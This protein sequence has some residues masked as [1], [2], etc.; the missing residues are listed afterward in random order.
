MVA[1]AASGAP[2]LAVRLRVEGAPATPASCALTDVCTIGAGSDADVI[3][4]DPAVSRRHFEVKLTRDGVRVR[5]LGSRNG[6]YYLGQRIEAA[7][8]DLGSV[9]TI[10]AARVVFEVDS[11]KLDGDAAPESSYDELLGTSPG[12]RR[13]FAILS[14][15]EGS[16]ASVLVEG[17]TGTGKEVVARAIHRRSRLASKSLV[18][19]NCGALDREMVKADL[20]GHRKGAFTG[21]VETRDGAFEMADG[22][23]LFLD[24]V[25]EVPLEVQPVLLRALETG[26]VVRVGED[27]ARRVTVRVIAAT[28]RDLEALV[29]QGAFREDLFYRL[30]VVRLSLPPL[31][32]RPE[33]VAVLARRFGREAG[34]RELPVDL[35]HALSAHSWPGNARELRNA[36]HAYAAIGTLPPSSAADPRALDVALGARVSFETTYAEQ[37]EELLQAFTSAYLTRLLEHTDGNQSEAA[38]ISGLERSY[39]GKLAAKV[40][41]KRG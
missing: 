25:G 19:V 13:L 33:D 27:T 38:R 5:D 18:A 12:M 2:P 24:E 6:T 9:V 34:L 15:L 11:S 35:E 3:V 7:T 26:E 32:E 29:R 22:G 30:A 39:L 41:A 16:L 36:I 8:L 17:E 14:R 23:T 37:K 10:G 4:D 31:R 21:A 40:G 28:N 20:F 1:R